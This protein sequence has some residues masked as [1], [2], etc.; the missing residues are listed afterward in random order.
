MAALAQRRGSLSSLPGSPKFGY[1][2]RMDLSKYD[3]NKEFDR[4]RSF[5]DNNW[6]N[7]HVSSDDLAQLGFFFSK[8]PDHVR[9]IFCK[10]HLS[11]FEPNDSVLEEHLKFSP[12][13]PLLRRRETDNVPLCAVE[14]NKILPAASYDECGSSSST[15]ARRKSYRVENDEV[16]FP[17]FKFPSERLASFAM[18]PVGI[19]QKPEELVAAGFF[20]SGH[21]DMTICFSCG[22]YIAKWEPEDNPWVEHKQHTTDVCKY[23][24]MNQST[25]QLNER[26]YEES[27][28][29]KTE[30]LVT[31]PDNDDTDKPEIAFESLCKICLTGK[32]SILFMPCRHVAVCG[33]CVFGIKDTCPICRTHIDDKIS[34]YFA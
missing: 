12:N 32:S 10:V 28:N 5:V 18:W 17:E 23:L 34:L 30:E 16:S 19:K 22:I 25:L 14:L 3:L 15:R 13:C 20:Y 33:Q 27:R 6:N 2:K 9:C 4:R 29:N 1:H 7:Q 11:E 26:L 21:S 24:E 31:S 8:Q